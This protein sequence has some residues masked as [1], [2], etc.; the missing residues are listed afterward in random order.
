MKTL[1]IGTIIS[2]FCWGMKKGSSRD[3]FA[4]S[5]CKAVH[6]LGQALAARIIV[7]KQSRCTD[8]WS[9]AADALSKGDQDRVKKEMGDNL[10][11]RKRMLP[12]ALRA[13]IEN[14]LPDMELGLKIAREVAQ[15]QEGILIWEQP[16]MSLEEKEECHRMMKERKTGKGKGKRKLSK[17]GGMKRNRRRGKK[18]K[19]E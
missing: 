15:K 14:P 5:I 18:R 7:V 13:H 9:E 16:R 1:T 10:E 19:M 6:D 3:L 8:R 4:S 17:G 2:G 11:R 12:R